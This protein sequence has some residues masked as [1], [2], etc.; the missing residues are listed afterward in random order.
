MRITRIASRTVRYGFLSIALATTTALS[1][2]TTMQVALL[3]QEDQVPSLIGREL[4]GA[5]AVA[6][7]HGFRVRVE[8]K[9]HHPTIRAQRIARQDPEPGSTLKRERSIKAWLS[10]GPKRQEIPSVEGESLRAARLR[11]DQSALPIA[12]VIEVDHQAAEG[13]VVLQRP[14][15]GDVVGLGLGEGV[16]LLVSRGPGYSYVMPDLIGRS[17]DGVS[18]QL[19]R[20]GLK[21]TSVRRLRYPGVAQGLVVRQQPA[22]GSRVGRNTAITIEISAD[23]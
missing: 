21:L 12:R 23:S 10:L 2:A 1:A 13:R 22:A 11:L 8:G 16:A 14:S 20:A 7:R 4:Q 19:T 9:R 15:A 17:W 6:E 18:G 5:T 3:A